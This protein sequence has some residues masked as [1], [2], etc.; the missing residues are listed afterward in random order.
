M[1]GNNEQ[2]KIQDY[3]IIGDCRAAALIGRN[4]SM[5]WLCWPQFDSPAIFARILDREQGGY[6][7]I[8]PTE[9]CDVKR[10]YLPNT[11]ILETRFA[12]RG[13]SAVLTDLMPVASEEY[14]RSKL[15][16]D[17][18]ILRQVEV[19]DGEVEIDVEFRPRED[20]GRKAPIIRRRGELGLRMDD[21]RGVYWLRSTHPL[22]LSQENDAAFAR[23]HLAAG[24]VARF[25]L[26]HAEESPAVLPCLGDEASE[27]IRISKDW[28]EQW[29]G[30]VSYNS[31]YRDAVVRSALTLKLLTYAPS[32]AI[33]AAAT[34]SLPERIGGKLNWDYRYCW[35]RDASLTV[36]ALI[37]LGC[38]AE[39]ESF[40]NWAL[41]ATRLTQ[42]ELRILYTVYGEN[43]PRERLLQHL[44]GYKDSRPVR[45]GNQAREQ[46]QLDVYG[47]VL[48]AVS[49]MAFHG[50]G[51]DRTTQKMLTEIG[52]YVVKN[53]R[54]PDEGIWEPRG[55]RQNHTYARLLCWTA[56][57]RLCTMAKNGR[58]ENAPAEL[59]ARTREEVRRDV[60]E[61]GWN[62]DVGS[63]VSVLGGNDLDASLL[64]MSW[65]GF[66]AS[67]SER[68]RR[69]YRAISSELRAGRDL[70]YRYK[71]SQGEGAFGI[72]GF[73][74]AEYLALGGGTLQQARSAFERLLTYSNDLGLYAEEIDADSYDAL[75]NFPQAFTHVGLIGAALSLQEREQGT[76]Q[77]AHREES[78]ERTTAKR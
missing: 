1:A 23:L 59:F 22:R 49:Q 8:A 75:G 65:Y 20:Y 61:N 4:G 69:T 21:G 54:R 58:L 38:W 52:K 12:C 3:A 78:A 68:M 42:P 33:V 77:L 70:L 46:L 55:S 5:D 7:Q 24:D 53:W 14:K 48:D 56:L 19:P 47:E 25:S 62:D 67:D 57:D 15:V 31:R 26:S 10:R 9:A 43:A 60:V 35:L 17:H 63:Y 28:W 76:Q 6:W 32:G 11:N 44:R 73:W 37:G 66:E 39:A 40:M 51:F 18:E 71:T 16:A 13:G 29:A 2:Q 36:R 34:T 50:Q 41:N 64:L 74:E 45:I 30:Q 27:R 72:C